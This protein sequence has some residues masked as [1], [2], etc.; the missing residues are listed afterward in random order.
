MDKK[1]YLEM[2][3]SLKKKYGH[4]YSEEE[5]L[6]DKF[7]KANCRVKKWDIIKDPYNG[8]EILVDKITPIARDNG[9]FRFEGCSIKKGYIKNKYAVAFCKMDDLQNWMITGHLNIPEGAS[10]EDVINGGIYY[11]TSVDRYYTPGKCSLYD[12]KAFHEDLEKIDKRRAILQ[13]A[14]DNLTHYYKKSCAPFEIGSFVRRNGHD[15]LVD[16]YDVDEDTGAF[17]R[18]IVYSVLNRPA[19]HISFRKRKTIL[20]EYYSQFKLV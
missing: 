15:Y 5:D 11:I 16:D 19:P 20:G 13:G 3:R 18:M 14:M 2:M 12:R 8:R 10:I 17:K 6:Y 7:A 1:M 4:L 9:G